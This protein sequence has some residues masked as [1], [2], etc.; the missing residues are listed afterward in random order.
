MKQSDTDA[1]LRDY[2]DDARF[3][4]E[5]RTYHGRREIRRFFETFIA[6]LPPDGINRFGKIV[7]RTFA[8]HPPAAVQPHRDRRL[9]HH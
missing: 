2:D 6:P 4:G 8:I 9:D 3:L 1:I 7:S 5:V